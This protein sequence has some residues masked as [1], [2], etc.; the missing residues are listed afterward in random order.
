MFSHRFPV[1]IFV[2]HLRFLA[3]R[4]HVYVEDDVIRSGYMITNL[5]FP[6]GRFPYY[7][8]NHLATQETACC[9]GPAKNTVIN[10]VTK[11][12]L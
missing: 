4:S 5:N 6:E 10:E 1:S 2:K 9:W 11:G 7:P 8:R 3:A 12:C